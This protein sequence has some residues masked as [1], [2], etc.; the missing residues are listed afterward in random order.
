MFTFVSKKIF[1]AFIIKQDFEKMGY[2]LETEI[3]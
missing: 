1:I 2:I 3:I